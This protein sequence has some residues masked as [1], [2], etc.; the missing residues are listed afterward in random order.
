MKRTE[1]QRI[2]HQINERMRKLERAGLQSS[3]AY[4]YLSRAI[5]QSGLATKGPLPR[6]KESV[7]LD[8]SIINRFSDS[9][10]HKIGNVGRMNKVDKHIQKQFEKKTGKKLTKADIQR[11]HEAQKGTNAIWR[12]LKDE[13]FTSEQIADILYA[14]ADEDIDTKDIGRKL[15]WIQ[16]QYSGRVIPEKDKPL[17]IKYLS[18]LINDEDFLKEIGEK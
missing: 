11:L 14:N 12:R 18:G 3:P 13:G 16:S 15:E 8:D 4:G 17:M 9:S 5:E 7:F 6:L 2:A 10:S 1:G